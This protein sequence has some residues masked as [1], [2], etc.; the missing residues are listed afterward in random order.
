MYVSDWELPPVSELGMITH[1][2]ISFWT[3]RGAMGAAEHWASD[4]S[5]AA[6]YKTAGITVMIS[7][8]GGTSS[9]TSDNIDAKSC[10][11][12]L[13]TFAIDNGFG[14]VDVNYEDVRALETGKAIDWLVVFHNELRQLLPAGYLITHAPVAAWFVASKYPGGGYSGLHDL[15]GNT[16]EW[17]N[18]QVGYAPNSFGSELTLHSSITKWGPMKHAIR[19]SIHLA[20]SFQDPPYSRY[21]PPQ[22]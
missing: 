18:I 3:T 6:G 2:I 10:A 4:S 20:G 17:Y 11:S 19:C 7:A 1:L 5:A 21:M 15:I 13:A 22:E 14:G 8:F 9:P 12:D 16:V